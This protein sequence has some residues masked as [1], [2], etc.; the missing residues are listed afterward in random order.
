MGIAQAR[1]AQ[2]TR[3]IP[4]KTKNDLGTIYLF[5]KVIFCEKINS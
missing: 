4:A 5:L 3:Y 2:S 1:K